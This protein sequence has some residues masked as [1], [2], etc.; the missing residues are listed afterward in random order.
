[1]WETH[2]NCWQKRKVNQTEANNAMEQTKCVILLV[3]LAGDMSTGFELSVNVYFFQLIVALP[4]RCFESACCNHLRVTMNWAK[5]MYV[6]IYDD[7]AYT[8]EAEY[9]TV[10][11]SAEERRCQKKGRAG[12]WQEAVQGNS[13]IN[14]HSIQYIVYSTS[15]STYKV[16]YCY[17]S[18]LPSRCVVILFVWAFILTLCGHIW[19]HFVWSVFQKSNNLIIHW[20]CGI[21][22]LLAG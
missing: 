17:F 4:F 11:T 18:C 13:K 6:W 2:C 19:F 12:V 5:Q 14:V 1:M 22:S 15:N 3:L 9:T 16:I 21:Y 20:V 7:A 8:C 10:I